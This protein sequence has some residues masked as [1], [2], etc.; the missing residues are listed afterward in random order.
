MV[1]FI[2]KDQKLHCVFS[3]HFDTI[4]AMRVE[5]SV[6]IKIM[7][8]KMPVV[9]DMEDV[10]YICSGFIRICIKAA[11]AAGKGNFSIIHT[12]PSVTKTIKIAG[13]DQFLLH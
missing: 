8:K 11:K 13:L 12:D 6:D 7:Q 4:A 3:G 9:F 1:E 5:N 10:S 2:L